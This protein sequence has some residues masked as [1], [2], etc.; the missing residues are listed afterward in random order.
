MDDGI[1]LK[2]PT[3]ESWD[4]ALNDIVRSSGEARSDKKGQSERRMS[5]ASAMQ[6]VGHRKKTNSKKF[7]R[8][9]SMSNSRSMSLS[10][11]GSSNRHSSHE[12]DEKR[13][14]RRKD[15]SS[16]RSDDN[17]QAERHGIG[18]RRSPSIG[19][20]GGPDDSN[21]PTGSSRLDRKEEKKSRRRRQ[22]IGAPERNRSRRPS[23]TVLHPPKS[24]KESRAPQRKSKRRSSLG[25]PSEK[26][27]GSELG[28][29]M[30]VR[31]SRK[32]GGLETRSVMPNSKEKLG[33]FIHERSSKKREGLASRTVMPSS[34]RTKDKDGSGRKD[35][36]R[37][38]EEWIAH[39]KQSARQESRKLSSKTKSKSS[40][41]KDRKSHKDKKTRRR[42]RD[43]RDEKGLTDI[44]PIMVDTE[45]KDKTGKSA[46][47]DQHD[48]SYLTRSEVL[49]GDQSQSEN[50]P[51]DYQESCS[52]LLSAASSSS[53]NSK[54]KKRKSSKQ[55]E[56]D[57]SKEG[58]SGR[59][60]K[61]KSSHSKKKKKEGRD[62]RKGGAAAST[63]L[64]VSKW[65]PPTR[66]DVGDADSVSARTPI[67]GRP[68]SPRKSPRMVPTPE[69]IVYDEEDIFTLYTWSTVHQDRDE[70]QRERLALKEGL[71]KNPLYRMYLEL[72]EEESA[73]LEVLG[74]HQMVPAPN[75][76]PIPN[77]S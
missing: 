56:K 8:S 55:K 20:S 41:S 47:I 31:A 77:W 23:A 60:E 67:D 72:E 12:V 63:P 7:N 13:L 26:P 43:L 52:T 2:P 66:K 10:H 46:A 35:T 34:S 76:A 6:G 53:K 73:G 65:K 4:E 69:N 44:E 5:S 28:E 42:M 49:K 24:S 38:R 14:L 54:K 22:S 75:L 25:S 16:R 11:R 32:K 30:D 9:E 3:R 17:G 45:N 71:R 64:S 27:K 74:L 57:K 50:K 39:L 36:P 48:Q 33:S 70:M 51:E 68:R 29:F 61:S 19:P 18:R 40:S 1:P 58:D 15:D 62:K 21:R 37:T 59:D